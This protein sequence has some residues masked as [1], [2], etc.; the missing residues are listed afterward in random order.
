MKQGSLIG[1]GLAAAAV[2][3]V[4]VSAYFHREKPAPV[5]PPVIEEP[6]P[7]VEKGPSTKKPP[8]KKPAPKKPTPAPTPPAPPSYENPPA[9]HGLT[10]STWPRRECDENGWCWT[11]M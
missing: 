9:W 8:K 1:Y 10:P 2:T 7:P 4:I 6:A 3:L 5:A 11:W